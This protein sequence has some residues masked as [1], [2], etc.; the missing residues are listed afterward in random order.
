MTPEEKNPKPYPP[1]EEEPMTAAEPVVPY[2][3]TD[4]AVNRGMSSNPTFSKAEMDAMTEEWL[5]PLTM[6]QVNRWNE[7]AEAADD[8]DDMGAFVSH[9]VVMARM[10][11]LIDSL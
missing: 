8:A 4:F 2:Q 7:A 1:H 3:R 5:R 9:E 10:K 11:R 6:E